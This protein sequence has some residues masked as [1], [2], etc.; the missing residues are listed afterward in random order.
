MF[1]MKQKRRMV[2]NP[3]MH[4]QSYYPY[5]GF[6]QNHGFQPNQYSNPQQMYNQS[7]NAQP[8]INPNTNFNNM[9]Q[10]PNYMNMNQQGSIPFQMPYPNQGTSNQ[11]PKQTSGFGSILNQ[12]KT[13]EGGYDVNKMMDTAGQM[14]NTVNQLNGVFKQVGTFFKPKA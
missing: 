7:T 5:Q 2:R 14:V 12:F 9:N 11:T 8:N 13:K 6:Q 4:N 10:Y 1:G 3:F